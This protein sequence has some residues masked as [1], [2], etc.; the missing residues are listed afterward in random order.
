MID[1]AELFKQLYPIP[2]DRPK[3][4][5]PSS[6][7]LCVV[8]LPRYIVPEGVWDSVKLGLYGL[9]PFDGQDALCIV[10]PSCNDFPWLFGV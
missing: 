4:L 10:Q 9:H 2:A 7:P 8:T 5:Y 3:N 6:L 1:H